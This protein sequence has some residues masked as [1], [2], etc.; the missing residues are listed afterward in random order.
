MFK[1]VV[2]LAAMIFG[3]FLLI[4]N[5]NETD[6]IYQE[7]EWDPKYDYD[8]I[9]YTDFIYCNKDEPMDFAPYYNSLIDKLDDLNSVQN[10]FFDL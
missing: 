7:C 5:V 4:D 10:D 6:E 9:I 3:V 8:G 1:Y 2:I